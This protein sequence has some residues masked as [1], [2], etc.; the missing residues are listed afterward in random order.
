MWCQQ[1]QPA[2]IALFTGAGLFQITDKGLLQIIR[3]LAGHDLRR[4]VADQHF[5]GVHQRNAVAAL[6]FIHKMGRDKNGDLVLTRQ[7]DHQLPELV[8]GDG[9]DAGSRFVED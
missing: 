9:V 6:G 5:A 3:L 8:A 4:C 7:I 1:R 2:A